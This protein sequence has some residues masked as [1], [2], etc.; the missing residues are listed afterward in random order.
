MRLRARGRG[1]LFADGLVLGVE[2]VGTEGRWGTSLV[3][4]A[5]VGDDGSRG[6]ELRGV[7]EV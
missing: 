3:F 5:G 2:G 4:Y 6:R 7:G 1:G